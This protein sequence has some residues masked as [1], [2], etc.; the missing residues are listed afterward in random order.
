MMVPQDA[1]TFVPRS[2]FRMG[3]L[4]QR[5]EFRMGKIR[6]TTL[7]LGVG[8]QKLGKTLLRSAEPIHCLLPSTH[9]FFN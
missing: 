2:E 7:C 4:G 3:K 8:Q 9:Y 1:H 5:S 6:H